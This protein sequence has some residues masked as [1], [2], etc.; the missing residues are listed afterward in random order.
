M[1]FEV[2]YE[3][4]SDIIWVCWLQGIEN[5]PNIVQGCYRN[6]L[7]NAENR[8]VILITEDNMFEYVQFPDYIIEKYKKGYISKTH[9]SDL[10][11]TELLV[12][13]GG[14]WVDSTVLLTDRIPQILFERPLFLFSQESFC[15]SRH[16]YYNNWFIVA[17]K[18]NRILRA[19]RSLLFEY[20]KD[21]D[22]LIDYFL[23][24]ICMILVAEKY[25]DDINNILGIADVDSHF[26]QFN[27]DKKFDQHY[28]S[29]LTNKT[30]IHKLTYKLNSYDLDQDFET[31][32]EHVIKIMSEIKDE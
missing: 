9:F 3:P 11:R 17:Q 26:L 6:L 13:Y 5:A 18:N 15:D 7:K 32:Y 1:D 14:I 2:S 12:K 10:L 27:F 23:W 25:E 29:Y 31:Y 8:K 24:H 4:I 28:W 16:F 19:V 20:Y 21:N 22:Y 30:T